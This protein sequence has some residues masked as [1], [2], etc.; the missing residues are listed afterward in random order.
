MNKFRQ[1]ITSIILASALL[2]TGNFAFAVSHLDC[3]VDN[4]A[5]HECE[6]ECCKE[7]D[8]CP[9]ESETS[10]FAAV[11]ITSNDNCC[12]VH[13]E[14]AAEQD[15]AIVLPVVSL[16]KLKSGL[17]KSTEAA[18]ETEYIQNYTKLFTHKFQTTNIYLSV[19]NLRI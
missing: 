2:F 7:S 18:P 3:M 1:N 4:M 19:S 10:D 16:D 6:M 8:C 17:L 15:N 5:H 9:E 11:K 14:Q 12:D 13:V